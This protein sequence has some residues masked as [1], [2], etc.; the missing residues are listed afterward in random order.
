MFLQYLF[1]VIAA[2]C[3]NSSDSDKFLVNNERDSECHKAVFSDSE[4]GAR[5]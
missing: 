5:G 4:L 1:L 2:N 3:K